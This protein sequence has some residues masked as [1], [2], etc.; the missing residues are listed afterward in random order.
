MRRALFLALFLVAAPARAEWWE[1]KTEHFIVDSQSSAEDAKAFATRLERFDMALRS[2]QNTRFAPITSDSQRLTVFRFGKIDD[3]GRLAGSEGIAGFYIPRLGGSVAFTPARNEIPERSLI[4]RD[5]RTDLDP[6]SVLFHE[7]THHFMFQNFSAAYPSW[8]VEGFAETA[9]TI[10]LHPDGSF[11]VGNPPQ[12]RSD[13]LLNGGMLVS[14]SNMLTNTDKPD[15][16]DVYGHY[17]V[18]WLLN[19]YL[20]FDPSRPGQLT[21]YLRLINSGTDAAVAARQAFGD[22]RKLDS[23]LIHYIARGKL[24]GADVRPAN[25]VPPTVVLRRLS[26][27]EE[28]VMWVKIR[29]KRGVTHKSAPNVASDARAVVAKFPHSFPVQLAASEAELD[30]EHFT[31]AEALADQALA[32][33]PNSV[34]ALLFKGRILLERAKNDPGQLAAA[35][36]WFAKAY[37]ADP[38]HPGPLYY[39]YLTYYRA[40]GTIPESALIGLERAFGYAPFDA[41]LREVLARQLLTEKK[42]DLAR[43]VLLPLAVSPHESKLAKKMREVVDLIAAQKVDAAYTM[44]AAEMVEQERKRKAGEDGE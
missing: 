23:D 27:D 16:F 36:P 12:Y 25:Y 40:G 41:E 37:A 30:A 2:M 26:A 5:S 42:G 24:G 28:A 34:E 33:A 18:G 4:R 6:Q 8:Y 44:L 43:T 14:A 29:S 21:T 38:K 10:D 22:L 20:S 17:T 3:I 13:M 7:Y 19:H 11:H 32:L 31:E 9:A 35:R 1:A 39:N 15:F